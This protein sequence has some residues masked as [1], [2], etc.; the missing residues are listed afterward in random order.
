MLRHGIRGK[1]CQFQEIANVAMD[2]AVNHMLFNSF[3]FEYE[4]ITIEKICV[5]KNIWPDKEIDSNRSFEYYYD[6]LVQNIKFI[7]IDSLSLID[8][9]GSDGSASGEGILMPDLEDLN[10]LLE[11]NGLNKFNSGSEKE[12]TPKE[13]EQIDGAVK[14]LTDV[15]AGIGRPGEPLV[16][17]NAGYFFAKQ[18]KINSK[19]DKLF[20]K[21]EKD[22]KD[23]YEETFVFKNRHHSLLGHGFILPFESEIE[24][25][26][27]ETPPI[28]MFL[29]CSGSCSN[30][31]PVFW[32]AAQS[33][34]TKK[35]KVRYFARTTQVKEIFAN[36]RMEKIG[37]SDDFRCIENFIQLQLKNKVIKKY[38][39]VIHIT[40]GGDCSGI[41]VTP[42]S[43]EKWHTILS[44]TGN[45][46]EWCPED[47]N[48]HYLNEFQ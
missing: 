35:F 14:D 13:K 15:K 6:L 26:E 18:V 8:I 22:Y 19:W 32:L 11:Q 36:Q 20:L 30:L 3:E 17:G 24:V 43:P 33:V 39:I 29:D 1:E 7:S 37:G 28:Y 40:D 42:Q 41:L 38:P 10:D 5:V 12:L 16:T 31:V 4:K 27:P 25:V 45:S 2:V 23:N 21:I 34:N 44:S 48:I 46:K 47:G 9:H